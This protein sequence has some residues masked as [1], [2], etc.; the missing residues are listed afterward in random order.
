MRLLAFEHVENVERRDALIRVDDL[1]GVPRE[2]SSA[3]ISPQARS[4]RNVSFQTMGMG[5][6][7]DDHTDHA[8]ASTTGRQGEGRCASLLSS[9]VYYRTE[10]NGYTASVI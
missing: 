7:A 3:T 5:G 9:L 10:G 2:L 1:L 4:E 8:G 6:R